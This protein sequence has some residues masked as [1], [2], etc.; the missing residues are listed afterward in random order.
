MYFCQVQCMA[1]LNNTSFKI[2]WLRHTSIGELNFI[3]A[4]VVETFRLVQV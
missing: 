2:C 1:E 4:I 3:Y